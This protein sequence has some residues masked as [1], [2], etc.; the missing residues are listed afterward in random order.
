M[1]RI[2]GGILSKQ[3]EIKDSPGRSWCRRCHGRP[4]QKSTASTA[5]ASAITYSDSVTNRCCALWHAGCVSYCMN[6]NVWSWLRLLVLFT[7]G[8]GVLS[9]V[10]D[11]ARLLVKNGLLIT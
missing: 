3:F 2:L 11:E 9:A 5:L 7:L 6:Q 1:R 4:R 8:P 10:P